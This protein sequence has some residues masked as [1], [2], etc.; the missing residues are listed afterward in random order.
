MDINSLS[1]PYDPDLD[2]VAPQHFL[3]GGDVIDPNS[4][5]GSLPADSAVSATSEPA[6]DYA[7]VP[8]VP[9][10]TDYFNPAAQIPAGNNVPAPYDP[11][12]PTG[13]AS[14]VAALNLIFNNAPSGFRNQASNAPAGQT[15]SRNPFVA[16]MP[17]DPS[18]GAP[19]ARQDLDRYN[20]AVAAIP[21]R[22]SVV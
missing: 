10:S 17:V 5:G 14:R 15:Y 18:T 6:P 20:Q 16:T 1:R 13:E 19:G 4:S 3:Q 11:N 7:G 2:D 8:T 9:R 22:K 12:D 21:D